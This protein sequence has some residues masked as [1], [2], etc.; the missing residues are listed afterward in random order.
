M[1]CILFEE[2]PLCHSMP[3][4][5]IATA[6]ASDICQIALTSAQQMSCSQCCR[7]ACVW[8]LSKSAERQPAALAFD[9]LHSYSAKL[10]SCFRLRVMVIFLPFCS[11][12][13]KQWLFSFCYYKLFINFTTSYTP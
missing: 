3:S 6:T 1:I 13:P 8:R 7:Y 11:I 12:R 10:V 4:A 9:N 2:L 5:A